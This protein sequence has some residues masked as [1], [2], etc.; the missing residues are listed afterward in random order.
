MAV[1]CS[2]VFASWRVVGWCVLVVMIVLFMFVVVCQC[3]L[4]VVPRVACVL[5]VALLRCVCVC[6]AAL[7]RFGVRYVVC[8]QCV[9]C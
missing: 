1:V 5:W 9:V 2:G 3:W 7:V 8:V 6:V 4:V